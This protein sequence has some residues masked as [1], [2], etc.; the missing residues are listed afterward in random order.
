MSDYIAIAGTDAEIV[1]CYPVMSELRP[2][3]PE[4]EFVSRVRSQQRAGYQLAYLKGPDEEIVA[5]AGF[6]IGENL[7]WGRFLYIDDLVTLAARRSQGYGHRLLDWLK[8]FA[9]DE[10]CA[11]IHLDSGLQRLDA[12]RFYGREGVDKTGFHFAQALPVNEQTG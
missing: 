12:H 7:A 2:H 9:V 11:Q 6:R 4:Q 1:A 8:Q 10:G 5:V 3:I